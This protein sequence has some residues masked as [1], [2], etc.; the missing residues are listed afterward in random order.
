MTAQ[1]PDRFRYQGVDYD[2][3]G[4]SAAGLFSPSQFGMEPKGTCTACWRGYQAVFALAGSRLVLDT[5]RVELYRRGKGYRRQEGPPING[6]SP[7]DGHGGFNNHYVG[8]NVHL[9]YTGGL[10]LARGFLHELY[11]HMGF[12]PAWKYTD[13]VELVFEKGVLQRQFDRSERMAE[14]RQ[15]VLQSAEPGERA[16][17]RA[18]REMR[19]FIER[20]FDRTYRT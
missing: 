7:T 6:V 9:D 11:V 3:A 2:L 20:S 19:E 18:P 16:G 17:P 15:R 4:I 8:I 10:L 12:Y 1:M 5:L 13:V 14:I